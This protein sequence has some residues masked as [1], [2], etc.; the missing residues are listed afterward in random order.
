MV[1]ETAGGDAACFLHTLVDGHPVDPDTW[2]DVARMRRAER[3]RLYALRK[4]FSPEARAAATE[5]IV[6]DLETVTGPLD[7]LNVSVYWPIRGEPDLRPWMK[8]AH[9]AGARILLPV[10]EQKGQPLAFRRWEP[11]AKMERGIW[12]IPVPAARETGLPDLVVSPL[13]GVD[14]G[15]F[16]LGNG[17]GYYD[18]T[19]ARLEPRPRII[20]VGLPGCTLKT[21]FPM[22]WDVPMDT[23]VLGDGAPR[24][25]EA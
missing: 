5:A 3:E 8:E 22:P 15:C 19:L 25:R 10:V 12:N 23:I 4:A 16:R 14:E 21:I 9:E 2:R 6:R 11:R 7:G 24:H 20:G 17:G 18:M 1:D 13:V